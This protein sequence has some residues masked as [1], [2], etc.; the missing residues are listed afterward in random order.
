MLPVGHPR[1]GAKLIVNCAYLGGLEQGRSVSRSDPDWHLHPACSGSVGRENRLGS[2]EPVSVQEGRSV[3]SPGLIFLSPRCAR[4]VG[5]SGCVSLYCTR[6]NVRRLS[7]HVAPWGPQ[8]RSRSAYTFTQHGL[9]L[10]LH[11]EDIARPSLPH[12][13]AFGRLGDPSRSADLSAARGGSVGRSF[14]PKICFAALRAAGRSV[15]I[16]ESETP[17]FRIR[18]RS[19]FTHS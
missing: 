4:R 13:R 19:V 15:G 16:R 3:G 14:R 10:L 12:E 18:G 9:D 2:Q 11:T 6:Y 7:V 17:R 5:R 1:G 8:Y